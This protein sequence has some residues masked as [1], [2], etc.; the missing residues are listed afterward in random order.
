MK[1]IATTLFWIILLVFDVYNFLGPSVGIGIMS[2]LVIVTPKM[3]WAML[4]PMGLMGAYIFGMLA[5]F[6]IKDIIEE[7]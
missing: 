6:G 1:S 7:I 5:W 4:F 2:E 3:Y